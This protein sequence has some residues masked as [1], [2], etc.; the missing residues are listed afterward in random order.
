M[1]LHISSPLPGQLFYIDET[2]RM[3]ALR[4]EAGLL[5]GN[6]QLL[7]TPL[8]WV[9]QIA[10]N[11]WPGACP[12]AKIGRQVINLQGMSMGLGNWIPSFNAICGGDA[13]LSVSADYLG[14]VYRATVNFRIRGKNPSPEAV[15][16]RLGGENS[17]MA[18]LGRYL[19]GLKQFDMQGMPY[20]GENGEVGIIRF[21]E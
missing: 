17:A 7:K 19:S 1:R 16:D 21:H 10:E 8:Q 14:E 15:L 3:P 13:T 2:G 18:R 11:V 12:N 9:L 6:Q 5:D 20:L 4:F